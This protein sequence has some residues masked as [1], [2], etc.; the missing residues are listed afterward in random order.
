MA[1]RKR[2]IE[3]LHHAG[4][5]I[6]TQRTDTSLPNEGWERLRQGVSRSDNSVLYLPV[7]T[8]WVPAFYSPSVGK[9]LMKRFRNTS[10][11]LVWNHYGH[12]G[13]GFRTGPLT[14]KTPVW[15][16]RCLLL[17]SH[18]SRHWLLTRVVQAGETVNGG[19]LTNHDNQI[20]LGTANGMTISTGWNW[21]RT[22][23]KTPVGNGYRMAG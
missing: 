2:R 20:V 11:R 16:L 12:H 19:T 21:G 7:S 13:G 15:R 22:V 6:G 14:G 4:T 9:K 18:Q 8:L 10:Y 17:L 3:S 5:G 1:W 23:K